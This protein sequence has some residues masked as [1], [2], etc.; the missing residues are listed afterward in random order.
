MIMRRREVINMEALLFLIGGRLY[1]WIEL[2]WRGRT[3][4][5]MF[6]LGGICFVAIGL[7]NENILPWTLP[8][9]LQALVGAGVVTVLEFV[10]GCIV[11]LGLGWAVW[12]YSGMPLNILGQV[13]LPYTLL[14]VLL[15]LVCIVVDDW[16][17]YLTYRTICWLADRVERAGMIATR[18]E[19]R[20]RPHYCLKG[21]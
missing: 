4:W 21:R 16:L 5:S 19:V 7:L 14:W 2:A 17:R 8:V 15:S 10:V 18:L 9:W 11:N 3:H 12:D 1:T 20:E 13:C 6:L